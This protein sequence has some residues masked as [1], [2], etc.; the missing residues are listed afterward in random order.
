MRSF[1]GAT[2]VS[3]FIGCRTVN[4]RTLTILAILAWLI[5]FLGSFLGFWLTPAKDFGLS[6]G[7]NKVGVWMGW[8]A[9]ALTLAA[10]SFCLGFQF[11]KGDVLRK[12]SKWPIFTM[13]GFL[14]LGVAA[15]FIANA[16]Y[17]A[18]VAPQPDPKRPTSA[19]AITAPVDKPNWRSGLPLP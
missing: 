4:A 6:A 8:Q 1:H 9:A 10:V 19:P 12:R 5:A 15:A 16:Y 17:N 14:I 13:V 3:P 7:W 11:E 18:N 2:C